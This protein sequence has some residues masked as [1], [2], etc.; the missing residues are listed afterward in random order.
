MEKIWR[1]FTVSSGKKGEIWHY[2]EAQPCRTLLTLLTG[3]RGLVVHI[4]HGFISHPS[5]LCHTIVK[6]NWHIR[7]KTKA[8]MT[9]VHWS[10]RAQ[11]FCLRVVGAEGCGLLRCCKCAGPRCLSSA[12]LCPALGCTTLDTMYAAV[13]T[14]VLL[15][16]LHLLP[17]I[18]SRHVSYVWQGSEWWVLYLEMASCLVSQCTWNRTT[19]Q[20]KFKVDAFSKYCT[21][22]QPFWT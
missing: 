10:M 13:Y 6:N 18:T 17:G 22:H 7:P 14:G 21:F 12:P 20:W 2:S 1:P 5:H 11:V 19:H 15:W 8:D 16:Q 9:L 3:L 4:F